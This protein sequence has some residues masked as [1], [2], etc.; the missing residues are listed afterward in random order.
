[1]I[2]VAIG[3]AFCNLFSQQSGNSEVLGFTFSQLRL[4]VND[5]PL[6]EGHEILCLI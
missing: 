4:G 3:T 2:P 6:E 5:M 1:M